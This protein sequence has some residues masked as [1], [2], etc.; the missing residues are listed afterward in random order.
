M[1]IREDGRIWWMVFSSI[2]G[3]DFQ[4]SPYCSTL[5]GTES[6]CSPPNLGD[7]MFDMVSMTGIH[8]S[9]HMVSIFLCSPHYS[10]LA[11][12]RICCVSPP[13]GDAML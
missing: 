1:V 8:G 5:A 3:V 13:N 7:A 2:V 9:Q 11:G 6:A 10:I 12:I 4:C